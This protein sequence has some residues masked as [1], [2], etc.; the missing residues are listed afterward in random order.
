MKAKFIVEVEIPKNASYEDVEEYIEFAV[1]TERGGRS[2]DDPLFYLNP[3]KI[4]V[5]KLTSALV[6]ENIR[7]AKA[8]LAMA[9]NQLIELDEWIKKHDGDV[10]PQPKGTSGEGRDSVPGKEW[11]DNS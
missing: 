10:T 1:R 4:R 2:P 11:K 9:L 7:L 3:K 8:N 5:K 6:Q